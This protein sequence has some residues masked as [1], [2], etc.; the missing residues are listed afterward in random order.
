MPIRPIIKGATLAISIDANIEYTKAPCSIIIKGPGTTPWIMK[1]PIRS[2]AATLPGIP[3][4]I[5][6]IKFEPTTALLDASVA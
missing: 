1:A 5:V 3:R 4:A 2:A 6:G